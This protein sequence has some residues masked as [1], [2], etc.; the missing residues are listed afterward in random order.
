MSAEPCEEGEELR[1]GRYRA[2]LEQEVWVLRGRQPRLKQVSIARRV[3]DPRVALD[4]GSATPD[5]EPQ[6]SYGVFHGE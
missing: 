6:A 1:V 5:L 2:N 3:D 4:D